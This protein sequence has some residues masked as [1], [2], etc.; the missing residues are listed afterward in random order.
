M[1]SEQLNLHLLFPLDYG[2]A[3]QHDKLEKAANS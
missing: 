2:L 3:F 1:V